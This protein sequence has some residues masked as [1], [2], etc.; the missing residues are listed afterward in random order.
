MSD[1]RREP[2][3]CADAS[4][5]AE[6]LMAVISCS[7]KL[8]I[9]REARSIPDKNP[10]LK[11]FLEA[12]LNFAGVMVYWLVEAIPA[13]LALKIHEFVYTSLAGG[14]AC[15]F[16]PRSAAWDWARALVKIV[17]ARTGRKPAMLA[18][19]SHPP[20]SGEHAHLMFDL[21]RH[22]SLALR[23]IRGKA[24]RPRVV[25]AVDAF[26]LDS[27]SLVGEGLYAGTM[28][29]YHIG[30]DRMSIRRSSLSASLLTRASWP[31]TIWRLT[32][33]LRSGGEAVMVLSGGVPATT[34][35]L[36]TSREW[37]LRCRA[38]SSLRSRPAE[39]LRRLREKAGFREF[40]ARGWS[41]KSVWR[42]MDLWLAAALQGGLGAIEGSLPPADSG[43]LD[44]E[45][46]RVARGCLEALDIAAESV[47]KYLDE[48]QAEF[49]RE[50]P[51]RSRLF[52]VLFR[53]V[54]ASGA[55][56]VLLPLSHDTQASAIRASPPWAWC[57]AGQEGALEAL[58]GGGKIADWK[59]GV[60]EFS[61]RFVETN[62]I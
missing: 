18:L 29:H 49:S 22:A 32:R 20:V 51:F 26:A 21:V 56:L 60:G 33:I 6:D 50:T 38:G 14:R 15:L 1:S 48:F 11:R 10:L 54:L 3:V 44:A 62:F 58:I 53:R 31:R 5:T 23:V 42:G 9:E 19:L 52:S 7:E 27:V 55:P 4:H 39:V 57:R 16:D 43:K 8:R 46:E 13:T 25:V 24:C 17:A 45:A 34:R 12:P 61:R 41:Q 28:G 36:Y 47:T 2:F 35:T 59:G 37:L 30:L 40:E